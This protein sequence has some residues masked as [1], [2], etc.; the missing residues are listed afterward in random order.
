MMMNSRIPVN[1]CWQSAE[2]KSNFALEG[3]FKHGSKCVKLSGFLMLSLFVNYFVR[4]YGTKDAVEFSICLPSKWPGIHSKVAAKI[5][6]SSWGSGW[7]VVG[8]P[9][10]AFFAF[11]RWTGF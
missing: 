3:F 2:A 9:R 8:D 10:K 5:A 11:N 7:T 6:S 1:D 4:I